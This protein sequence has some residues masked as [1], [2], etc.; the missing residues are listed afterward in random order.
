MLDPKEM[1][2]PKDKKAMAQMWW[3]IATAVIA[4]I[5]VVL[6]ILWFGGSGGKTF[7]EVGGRI[8]GLG[9]CDEDNVANMFDKC[10]CSPGT[11]EF[12]G[13]GSDEQSGK[14]VPCDENMENNCKK[15][16]KLQCPT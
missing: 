3:I 5:V 16:G 8:Q 4:L 7:D 11:E 13:C 15:C 1:L 10:P 14:G 2:D 9:D 12:K 6:V